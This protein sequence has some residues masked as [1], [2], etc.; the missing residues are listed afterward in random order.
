MNLVKFF[1][2]QENN[3]SQLKPLKPK[4]VFPFYYNTWEIQTVVFLMPTLRVNGC[5]DNCWPHISW[6]RLSISG[7][8]ELIIWWAY[9]KYSCSTPPTPKPAGIYQNLSKK[10]YIRLS[11]PGY[12]NQRP[13]LP[14]LGGTALMYLSTSL[15]LKTH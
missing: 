1:F 13:P 11:S 15:K 3:W 10:V 9:V 7:L 4:E 8:S 14:E 6:S 5:R 2:L 12:S